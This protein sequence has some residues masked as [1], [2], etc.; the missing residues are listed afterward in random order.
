M[1]EQPIT[2]ECRDEGFRYQDTTGGAVCLSEPTIARNPEDKFLENTLTFDVDNGVLLTK[3]EGEILRLIVSGQTNKQIAQK[4]SR[5]ERTV[6]FH[7]NRLMRKIG[8]HNAAE[9]VKVAIG[10]GLI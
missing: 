10:M 4:L 2:A 8:A 6:E 1:N 3:R 7:R 5:S 9:L